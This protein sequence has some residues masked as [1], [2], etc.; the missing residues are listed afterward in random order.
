MYKFFILFILFSCFYC[1]DSNAQNNSLTN[2]DRYTI[3]F[4]KSDAV[5]LP[6]SITIKLKEFALKNKYEEIFVMKN[7]TLLKPLFNNSLS[8]EDRIYAAD[9]LLALYNKPMSYIPLYLIE[10]IKSTIVLHNK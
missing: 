7:A 3:I 6:D 5:R 1:Y 10:E 4:G 8:M 9:Y 2:S